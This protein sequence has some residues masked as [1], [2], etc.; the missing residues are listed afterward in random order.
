MCYALTSTDSGA[1]CK[2]DSTGMVTS[3]AGAISTGTF[4]VTGS[5]STSPSASSSGAEEATE[6]PSSA[7][8]SS[9][10][11]ST[12][13]GAAG[14]GSRDSDPGSGD[15]DGESG[16]GTPSGCIDDV[17]SC[18]CSSSR[19]TCL[20]PCVTSFTS[21]PSAGGGAGLSSP[22]AESHSV[23]GLTG[24]SFFVLLA[25]E[26]DPSPSCSVTLCLR[27]RPIVGAW[28]VASERTGSSREDEV[29][30]HPT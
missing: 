16:R 13:S 4:V 27:L 14:S 2:T 30:Q 22:D 12:S 5:T 7:C 11:S 19:S 21:C 1:S 23:S 8:S 3:W 17:S 26:G 24:S 10:V 6:S 25:E 9:L 15:A 20:T 29:S 28:E 18:L